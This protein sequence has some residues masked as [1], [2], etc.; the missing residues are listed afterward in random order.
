MTMG[1]S[2]VI[3][4]E[5]SG[6]EDLTL[7]GRV[8]GKVSLPDH[9]L[10]VG[11]NAVIEAEVLAKEIIV[12]GTVTGDVTAKEKCELRAGASMSGNLT[13]PRIAM[14]EGSTFNGKVEMPKKGENRDKLLKTA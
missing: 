2:V 12:L 10:T 5:L 6:A 9:V 14:A 13:A 4:G 1:Q 8:E 7:D 11:A 3:K